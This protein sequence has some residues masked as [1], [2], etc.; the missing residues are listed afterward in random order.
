MEGN[1]GTPRAHVPTLPM[2][3]LPG[4]PR[5]LTSRKLMFTWRSMSTSSM[6]PYSLWRHVA[7]WQG[8]GEAGT[9]S[10]P[11]QGAPRA[12]EDRLGRR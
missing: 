3:T 6:V 12:G 1:L 4:A 8:R 2:P 10:E 5:G 11:P 9:V 7:L